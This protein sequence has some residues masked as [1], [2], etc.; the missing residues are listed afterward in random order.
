M[1]RFAFAEGEVAGRG[2]LIAHTGYTG[3]DG[4]ELYCAP[5]DAP[6]LWEAILDAG[7]SD[8][9]APAGLGARDTLRLEAALPLYGHEL[10]E[11]TT[12][13]EARLG[14]V[15]RMDKGDFVGRAA[16]R[17]SIG[18]AGR[19]AAWSAS[20]SREPGVPRAG[21]RI[22]RDGAR[23]RRGHQRHQVA[24]AWQGDCASA[25]W[26]LPRAAV[27][28][29]L[30]VEIRGRAVAARVVRL[31]FYRSGVGGETP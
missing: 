2:A 28:T 20:S 26:S 6:A 22:L 29:V 15:V 7:R 27:G 3:E 25:M 1:P 13:F 9:I 17:G 24:H 12:P 30:A 14:W 11:D 5:G 4:W 31:P 21:Y 16:L 19:A 8:G 23:G 10:G 18:S